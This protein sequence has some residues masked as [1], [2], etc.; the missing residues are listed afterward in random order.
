MASLLFTYVSG[1]LLK[2]AA[3]VWRAFSVP[4]PLFLLVLCLTGTAT[5]TA[6][7]QSAS[8]ATLLPAYF[9][10]KS[11]TVSSLGRFDAQQ[12]VNLPTG[13]AQLAI[14]L[15]EVRRGTLQLPVSLAYS[16]SGMQVYQP[17]DLVGLGWTLQAGAAITLQVNG[18]L[19]GRAVGSSLDP[20]RYNPDSIGV[21]SQPFL[22][23]AAT[24]T[25]D[26]G[27]D[28]YSYTIPGGT[29]GRFIIRDTVIVLLPQQPVC[30]RLLRNQV[31]NGFQ[32][33]FQLTT[34]EGVRYLF[35]AIERTRPGRNFSL[36]G[37]TSAWHLTQVISADN[38]DTL[39]LCYTPRPQQPTPSRCVVT[40]GSYHSG[41]EM[42]SSIDNQD[43][44]SP[45]FPGGFDCYFTTALDYS[46][47]NII[48][49]DTRLDTQYLDSIVTRGTVLVLHRDSSSQVLQ[50]VRLLSTIGERREVKR[51]TLFQSTFP[52]GSYGD[53][54]VRLDSL[55]ESANNLYLP[56]YRFTYETTMLIPAR[57][58]AAL[59]YWGYSNGAYLNGD[60]NTSSNN[61]LLADPLLG[62]N[63]ANREANYAFALAGALQQVT[64][65]TGGQTRW[66]YESGQVW[67]EP[68]LL[69]IGLADSIDVDRTRANYRAQG[70]NNIL[71]N[72]NL[73]LTNPASAR[74]V[75]PSDT[76]HFQIPLD[77][78]VKVYL[79]R[80]PCYNCPTGASNFYTDFNIWRCLPTGDT[81]IT[82]TR[83]YQSFDPDGGANFTF[84]LPAG[85]YALRVYC[86]QHESEVDVRLKIAD[87]RAAVL[88]GRTLPGA[89]IRVRRIHT[90]A[91]GAPPL[92]R[93]YAYLLPDSLGGHES[94]TTLTGGRGIA[95]YEYRNVF[96]FGNTC[97]FTNT[98]S[99]NSRPGDEFYKYPFYYRCV[100]ERDSSDQGATVNYFQPQA[101]NFHDVVVVK[102]QVF[103]QAAQ[104]QLVQQDDYTYASDSSVTSFP[105]LRAWMSQHITDNTSGGNGAGGGILL[106][107]KVEE[108]ACAK[109]VVRAAFT[110]LRQARHT[111]Y[112]A[113]GQAQT[114][115]TRSYYRQQRL[116]LAR[117][118]GSTGWHA[119]RY[120][121]LADYAPTLGVT[122]L[123][124]NAFNPIIETQTWFR[125][126]GRP[127]SV[128]TGG[129]LTFY[130]PQW[131][132]PASVYHLQLAQPQP[133]PN[134]ETLVNGKYTNFLSD[135]RYERQATVRYATPTG[136]VAQQQAAHGLP[137]SY[138]TGYN[139]TLLIAEAKNATYAQVA[140][141]SFEPQSTG[142]WQYDSTGTHRVAGVGRTG[143]W[144]YR[145]DGGAGVSRPQLPAGDYE[146]LYWAQGTAS[147]ALTCSGGSPLGPVLV[148]TAPGN[149]RQYRA[150]LHFTSTGQVTLNVPMGT[151]QLVD[152]VRLCPVGGRLTSYT[153]DPLVGM[154]SQTGPDGR[155]QTY[156]Y[157]ALGRLV[158]TRDEQG[159]ILGQQQYHYAGQ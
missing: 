93:S 134:Q 155:T 142:R 79:S 40:T 55:R 68:G 99:D 148:A 112:D 126:L 45:S 109:G 60:I 21:A 97:I 43:P 150:Q 108:Y 80:R 6:W 47:N 62:V 48:S 154:T 120:K 65:P 98:S 7:A 91:P 46:Y 90:L 58:S 115:T 38:S 158:R 54:R 129:Q 96:V 82:N 67:Y 8:P 122:S 137:T 133:G 124:V 153:H 116:A 111:V 52:G 157:D 141:T 114:T 37:Y 74:Y 70:P 51:F 11:P 130:S 118:S 103:R 125:P 27:P 87:N 50:R 69:P 83:P 63:Q 86:E 17:A 101:N 78:G 73:A 76:T 3:R 132:A 85:T 147:P 81:L 119:Q 57:S 94:G 89:G 121:R 14:P 56:A 127:D 31:G 44:G 128:L 9:L 4:E 15:A 100:T 131:R 29:S 34:D 26:T 149:W 18:R 49:T 138:L 24:S 10:P 77:A 59:D 102:R 1:L 84:Q 28:V 25:S 143:R 144:A 12:L 33:S 71:I 156:E 19:D 92:V 64:Y 39:R 105:L 23:R 13:A 151:S 110:A 61:C 72:P 117:T 107:H 113:Q 135:S 32:E 36:P 140:Y 139:H 5:P 22:K 152:E 136:D 159:R 16:Y 88:L 106:H 41:F 2:H 95:A 123:Q 75:T 30:I 104:L 145:L 35:R 146:L 53:Q 42:V 66:E 20:A